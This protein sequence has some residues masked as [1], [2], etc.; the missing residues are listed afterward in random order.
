MNSTHT[1]SDFTPPP[2]VSAPQPSPYSLLQAPQPATSAAI[3]SFPLVRF[4]AGPAC[5]QE[6]LLSGR[7]LVVNMS[8]L[9]RPRMHDFVWLDHEPRRLPSPSGGPPPPNISRQHAFQLEVDGELLH[10]SWEWLG[11]DDLGGE[12]ACQEAVV[13][14]RHARH[15][16]D[17]SLHTRVDGT[18]LFQRWLV[19]TNRGSRPVALSKVHPWSA[20]VFRPMRPWDATYPATAGNPF[21]I[22][23]FAEAEHGREGAFEWI[24]MPR[25]RFS[26]ESLRGRSGWG[27]PF[28]VAK[29]AGSG[30]LF[31]LQLAWSG[32]WEIECASDYE[33][34]RDADA[35][36]LY[37]SAGLTGPSP[38]RVLGAGDTVVTPV[39]HVGVVNAD[40]D[41][42]VHM[43]HAHHRCSVLPQRRAGLEHPVELNHTGFTRNLQVSGTQLLREA[44]VAADLGVELFVVDAGWFGEANS[45]WR[46]VVGDWRETPSIAAI[47]LLN[48][49]TRARELGMACGL[50]LSPEHVGTGTEFFRDHPEWLIHDGRGSLPAPDITIPDVYEH[51]ATELTRIVERYQLDCLRLD[52]NI[53]IGTGPE[54]LHGH[55]RENR[56]WRYYEALYSILDLL[57]SRFPDLVLENC[58]SGGGRAD[59]GMA[60]RTHWTQI[61]NSW[62]PAQ[63][64]MALC[65]TTLALP[66]E[67]CMV[68]T[69]AI[70][71]NRVDL[72]FA[73]RIGLFGQMC[74]S[75]IFPSLTEVHAHAH[76]RFRHTI[77]LYKRTI[78]PMLLTGVRFFHH[79]PP[80]ENPSSEWVGLELASLDSKRLVCG[81][82]A[83]ADVSEALTFYPRGVRAGLDYKI[84][85]DNN[86]SQYVAT[87]SDLLNHG[88]RVPIASSGRSELL[89]LEAC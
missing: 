70:S 55:F 60:S 58:S 23:R 88:V 74:L 31:V 72:D 61:T 76:T 33:P 73:L 22:G 67:S 17:V 16:I 66:P 39:A 62:A 7:Y 41:S 32:N 5:Y 29:R 11:F 35:A 19:V 37:V 38:L 21:L 59:L 42:L 75:G 4:D 69:G 54:A 45:Y 57:R 36:R 87:G 27:S 12:P 9:G 43:L 63:T 26:F 52:H 46:D 49:F 6:A 50:W 83:V 84:T 48:I 85:S 20:E 53:D 10:D 1:A 56:L 34:T 77:E 79:R 86:S 3:P 18:A 80:W 78:R 44:E 40:L 81:I 28:I 30:E 25:G 82:F 68:L 15:P 65:G 64:L 8:G 13:S 24:D 14:L 71:E 51:V 89:L 47:G 2:V